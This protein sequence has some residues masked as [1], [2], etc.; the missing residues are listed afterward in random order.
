VVD[1][2]L[3]TSPVEFVDVNVSDVPTTRQLRLEWLQPALLGCF[4]PSG[5]MYSFQTCAAYSYDMP[6]DPSPVPQSGSSKPIT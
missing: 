5:A 2:L 3:N 6:D 4:L 1:V